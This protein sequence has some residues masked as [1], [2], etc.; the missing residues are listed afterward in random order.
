V[1][2]QVFDWDHFIWVAVLHGTVQKVN[3]LGVLGSGN[4]SC[5]TVK[6]SWAFLGTSVPG[7]D[8]RAVSGACIQLIGAVFGDAIVLSEGNE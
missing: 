2:F 3:G 5:E 8:A 6:V 7:A 1:G 4:A